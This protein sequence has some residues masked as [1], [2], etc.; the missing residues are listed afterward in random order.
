MHHNEL[1]IGDKVKV[2]CVNTRHPHE[3]AY[4]IGEIGIVVKIEDDDTCQNV[5]LA[6]DDGEDLYIS[7]FEL[8]ARAKW[9]HVQ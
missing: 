6:M 2:V 8:V 9:E 4:R 3:L 7:T 5:K 1:V